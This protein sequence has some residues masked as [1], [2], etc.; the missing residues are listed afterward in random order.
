[1]VTALTVRLPLSECRH[2]DQEADARSD[3]FAFGAVVCE[4]A[5]GRKAFEG[6][7]PATVIAGILERAPESISLMQ[8]LASAAF[9]HIV[10]RCLAKDPERRWQ[11]VRDVLSE[12]QWVASQDSGSRQLPTRAIQGQ[13][14]ERLAWMVLACLL[15]LTVAAMSL[16]RITTPRASAPVRFVI[17]APSS[18]AF[19]LTGIP[20]VAPDG[21]SVAFV[22]AAAGRAPQLWI[23]PL[24]ALSAHPLAGTDEAAYPFRS[25][26]SRWLGFFA[27]GK[28]KSVGVGGEPPEIVCDAAIG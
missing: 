26:D 12:L 23:R 28:L 5:T 17:A 24:D 8:P 18:S 20:M 19:E 14:R 22:A 7:T 16:S 25:P 15:G 3:L 11:T 27:N 2:R 9:E 10:S 13:R 4:M 21:R 1:M 6:A